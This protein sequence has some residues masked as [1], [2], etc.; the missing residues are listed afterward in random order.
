M[1]RVTKFFGGKFKS[2]LSLPRLEEDLPE[3]NNSE[4]LVLKIWPPTYAPSWHYYQ[5]HQANYWSATE[6]EPL[7][8]VS[9]FIKLD[10]QWQKAVLH[11]FAIL[12]IGDDA[13][14][15]FIDENDLEWEE[16]TQWMFKDQ[17][18]RETIHKI[19]YNKMLHLADH[20]S[21][22][23]TSMLTSK[24][25]INYILHNN[26]DLKLQKYK[27]EDEVMK[28]AA[29]LIK[30][31]FCERYLFAT[32]FL[33]INLMGES[34]FLNNCVRINMQ[35]MKDEHVHYLHAVQLFRDLKPKSD[36]IDEI[37]KL[38]FDMAQEFV[39]IVENMIMKIGAGLESKYKQGFLDHSRFTLHTIYSDCGIDVPQSLAEYTTTPFIVFDK[40]TGADK[41]NLMESNST[42]YKAVRAQYV[43]DWNNLQDEEA[44]KEIVVECKLKKRKRD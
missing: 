20:S 14:M 26:S 5:L 23:T 3:Y 13:V 28:K 33:V 31:I 10:S 30:M 25:Y 24:K 32:P 40:N 42:V 4:T 43:P 36:Q 1:E 27:L 16:C 22:F 38:F 7:E 39:E 35:V 21:E 41:F 19:V 9:G 44:D 17:G 11:S 34:G 2:A 29:F 15:Q 37:N 12:A 6:H 18:A 8:D